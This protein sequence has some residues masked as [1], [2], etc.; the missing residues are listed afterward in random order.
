MS[1]SAVPRQEDLSSLTLTIE[2]ANTDF[3][4]ADEVGV[5]GERHGPLEMRRFLYA[6]ARAHTHTHTHAGMHD[7]KPIKGF[8][9]P[10]FFA[11]VSCQ[12]Q[13]R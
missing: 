2:V 7:L 3:G 5:E 12:L 6:C 4:G 1:F 9:A 13:S 11:R 10:A 8:T